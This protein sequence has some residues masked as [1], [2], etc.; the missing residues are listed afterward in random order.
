MSVQLF[1]VGIK[2]LCKNNKGQYLVLEVNPEHFRIKQESH[3]DIPGGRIEEGESVD[4]TLL[5]EVK[6]ELG[7]D[8]TSEASFFTAVVSNIKLPHGDSDEV[9]LVLM[10]YTVTLPEDAVIVLSEENLRYEWVSANE[11]AKRLA[12]K[13]PKEFTE[14]LVTND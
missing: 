14:R 3:W 11:A 4:T 8:I 9:G 1:H 7:I 6:E 12:F 13:Y 2:A 5:R 10:V